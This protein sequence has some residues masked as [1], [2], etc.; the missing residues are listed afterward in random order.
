M[1]FRLFDYLVGSVPEASQEFR[2]RKGKHS[3][4]YYS[5]KTIEIFFGKFT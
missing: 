1:N 5:V 2:F 4:K 3:A